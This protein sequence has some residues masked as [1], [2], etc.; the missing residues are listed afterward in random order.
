MEDLPYTHSCSLQPSHSLWTVG[1]P[2]PLSTSP[3]PPRLISS[4]TQK[5][6]TCLPGH[7]G[8]GNFAACRQTIDPTRSLGDKTSSRDQYYFTRT[9]MLHIIYKMCNYW[10][11]VGYIECHHNVSLW[12]ITK[13]VCVQLLYAILPTCTP[14]MCIIISVS[15][16]C[17]SSLGSTGAHARDLVGGLYGAHYLEQNV[18][19]GM[20]KLEP[21]KTQ[22]WLDRGGTVGKQWERLQKRVRGHPLNHA[23]RYVS[24]AGLR[25]KKGGEGGC[26]PFLHG[27]Q[28]YNYSKLAAC[29]WNSDV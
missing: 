9:V 8:K 28:D 27:Q 24:L 22:L 2:L 29:P 12:I 16:V 13:C 11:A 5:K 19:T 21:A 25:S 23:V 3:P 26:R 14:R 7:S 6:T 15:P 20:F 4:W 10:C 1:L 18:C 17:M